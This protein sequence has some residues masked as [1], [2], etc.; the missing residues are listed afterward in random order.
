[1]DLVICQIW[2]GEGQA[3]RN[4]P[5]LTALQSTHTAQE[6][7]KVDESLELKKKEAEEA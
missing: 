4:T 6:Q 5:A 3:P 2:G 1:M 7:D